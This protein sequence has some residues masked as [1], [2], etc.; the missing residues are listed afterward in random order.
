MLEGFRRWGHHNKWITMRTTFLR[1][2]HKMERCWVL[3]KI[4]LLEWCFVLLCRFYLC[5]FQLYKRILMGFHEWTM[6]EIWWNT[7]VAADKS[8]NCRPLCWNNAELLEL[9]LLIT[10]ESRILKSYCMWTTGYMFFKRICTYR[11]VLLNNLFCDESFRTPSESPRKNIQA[12]SLLSFRITSIIINLGSRSRRR[13]CINTFNGFCGVAPWSCQHTGLAVNGEPG[14]AWVRFPLHL[15]RGPQ[16]RWVAAAAEQIWWNHRICWPKP[17]NHLPPKKPKIHVICRWNCLRNLD[18]TKW[19][20]FNQATRDRLL[21]V[22][23]SRFSRFSPTFIGGKWKKREDNPGLRPLNLEKRWYICLNN[24]ART[25]SWDLEWV[26]FLIGYVELPRF[27][28]R[29]SL[30][31]IID[32]RDRDTHSQAH[33]IHWCMAYFL[34]LAW[35]F[36]VN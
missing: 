29:Q 32:G 4:P 33:T 6:S 21:M 35:F 17:Q 36:M 19:K 31:F 2:L 1:C 23:V 20:P 16:N 10:E 27:V 34:R 12:L 24:F 15:Q 9:E 11:Y 8:S 25:F 13:Q 28:H 5:L 3:V 22:F 30:L 26:I 18:V 7:I 14:S